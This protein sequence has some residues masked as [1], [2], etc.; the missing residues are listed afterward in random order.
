MQT[1][2]RRSYANGSP[3]KHLH[4]PRFAQQARKHLAAVI[5]DLQRRF[6]VIISEL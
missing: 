5:L 6:S 1:P 2:Q 3:Q 4:F